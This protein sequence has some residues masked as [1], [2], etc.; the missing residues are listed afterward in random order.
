MPSSKEEENGK[1]QSDHAIS[2]D[3]VQGLQLTMGEFQKMQ[4]P[5]NIQ[6]KRGVFCEQLADLQFL[7]KGQTCASIRETYQTWQKSS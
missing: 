6:V 4:E 2:L 1:H 5:K 7:D 3:M